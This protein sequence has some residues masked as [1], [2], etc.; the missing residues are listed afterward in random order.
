M[1]VAVSP[2]LCQKLHEGCFITTEKKNWRD[3]SIQRFG[4]YFGKIL[5]VH[6]TPPPSPDPA[7]QRG[8]RDRGVI[9]PTTQAFLHI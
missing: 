9:S 4:G 8:V 2:A 1:N 7:C 6:Y 5:G 3:P